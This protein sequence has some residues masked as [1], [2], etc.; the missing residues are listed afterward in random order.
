M[1][2]VREFDE[3]HFLVMATRDG[4]IKRTS[5]EAYRNV[6]KNGLIA[7]TL[8]EGDELASARLTDGVSELL[9]ATENGMCIRFDEQQV[10]PMSRTAR[11]VRG[12]SC[13]NGRP[14]Y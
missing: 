11:G 13:R 14:S 12:I 2:K 4:Y 5:L 8:N 1:I 3:D 7:I 9:L 10:R 6:R